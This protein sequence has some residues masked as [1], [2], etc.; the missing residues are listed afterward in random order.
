MLLLA[1]TRLRPWAQGRDESQDCYLS[2]ARQLKTLRRILFSHSLT[3]PL[4]TRRVPLDPDTARA[5]L[6]WRATFQ[7][8]SVFRS[9]TYIYS[10]ALA[11]SR[12]RERDI[13][14]PSN[15]GPDERDKRLGLR[16]NTFLH[17]WKQSAASYALVYTGK[18]KFVFITSLFLVPKC[19]VILLYTLKDVMRVW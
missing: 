11:D 1:G 3:I 15:V 10:G 19:A 13:Y 9:C 7:F 14:R 4:C 16:N 6:S 17:N 5:S 2:Y 12:E 8:G 18:E